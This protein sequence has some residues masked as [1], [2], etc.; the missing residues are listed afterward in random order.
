MQRKSS[1]DQT[2]G[3]AEPVGF[4][5]IAAVDCALFSFCFSQLWRGEERPPAFGPFLYIVWVTGPLYSLESFQL[6]R[7]QL[8][9]KSAGASVS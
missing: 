3:S 6:K 8:S 4:L 7:E 9:F 2:H 1:R 5:V